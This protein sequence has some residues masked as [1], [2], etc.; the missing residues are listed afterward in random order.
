[1]RK[2][3][4]IGAAVLAITVPAAASATPIVDNGAGVTR[5]AAQNT[6][7]ARVAIILQKKPASNAK[8]PAPKKGK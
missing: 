2:H 5:P 1:M 8:A 4:L 7:D 3:V 6:P